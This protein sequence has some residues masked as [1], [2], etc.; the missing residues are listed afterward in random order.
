VIRRDFD[1]A[2]RTELDMLV[3]KVWRRDAGQASVDLAELSE[4]MRATLVP[5][6]AKA[7]AARRPS[8][9]SR[10]C[11]ESYECLLRASNGH[12]RTR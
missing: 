11:P 10:R 7:A 9:V 6:A 8:R 2:E 1:P 4:G 12:G 3:L 5:A